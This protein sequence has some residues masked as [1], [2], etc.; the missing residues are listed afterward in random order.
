MINY[1]DVGL[2]DWEIT[3]TLTWYILQR[4]L[5]ERK[6]REKDDEGDN[7]VTDEIGYEEH[8]RNARLFC[9]KWDV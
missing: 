1:E 3:Q 6:E 2:T 7:M 8:L 9:I 5:C 4:C